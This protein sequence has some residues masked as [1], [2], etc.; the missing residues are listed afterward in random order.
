MLTEISEQ[1]THLNEHFN[2]EDWKRL[3][4]WQFRS[5]CLTGDFGKTTEYFKQT[6]FRIIPSLDGRGLVQ[7]GAQTRDF[8]K[9]VMAE[10][11]TWLDA[12]CV[13]NNIS[14]NYARQY[15]EQYY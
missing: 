6:E 14:V 13:E 7:L 5:E 4:V 12:Y 15:D 3:L 1:S 11:I 9:Y 10:F 8:P 2:V